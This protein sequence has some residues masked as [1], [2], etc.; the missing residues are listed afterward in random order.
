MQVGTM[1]SSKRTAT[2]WTQKLDCW[3]PSLGSQGPFA[4]NGLLLPKE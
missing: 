4:Y 3:K 1:H 2:E